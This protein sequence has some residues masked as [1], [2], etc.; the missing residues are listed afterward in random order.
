M[1][2]VSNSAV[3]LPRRKNTPEITSAAGQ[4]VKAMSTVPITLVAVPSQSAG[5]SSEQNIGV[6]FKQK[7][8]PSV[9]NPMP[10]QNPTPSQGLRT[11]GIV[12]V[13]VDKVGAVLVA[14]VVVV[15]GAGHV[16]PPHASQQLTRSPTQAMPRPGALHAAPLRLMLHV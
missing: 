1:T 4:I 5:V 2:A 14:V 6:P 7:Q 15:V 16:A 13:V 9:Q 8:K 10:V 3:S 12:L 11:D